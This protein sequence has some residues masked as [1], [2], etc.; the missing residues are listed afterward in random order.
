MVPESERASQQA[1]DPA[2]WHRAVKDG[3]AWI[4]R[5]GTV[6]NNGGQQQHYYMYAV[7]RY[8]AFREMAIA[9]PEKEP[10]W[11]NDGVDYLRKRQDADGSWKSENGKSV[12]TSFAILFL[13]RSSKKTIT[14]IQ[15]EQ[16]RLTGG[17]GLDDDLTFARVDQNGKVITEDVNK[18]VSELLKMIDDPKSAT[19]DLASAIPT[20][21]TL[22]TDPKERSQVLARLRRMAINGVFEGRVLACKTLGTVRDLDSAPA[23]IFALS[24]PDYRVVVAARDALQFMSRNNQTYGLVVEEGS[25]PDKQLVQAAQKKW[26]EWLLSVKPDAELLQ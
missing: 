16:G 13:L 1:V 12:D 7:E 21:I 11:Y 18:P 4:E 8:W 20:K 2:L 5:K 14:R 9:A 3:N 25:V 19:A 23:L 26:T 10:K 6:E 22:P 24:D 15:L 17:K